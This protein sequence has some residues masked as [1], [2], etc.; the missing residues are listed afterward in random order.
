MRPSHRTSAITI[1]AALAATGLFVA[2][3]DARAQ[4]DTN[5][6]LP[7]VMLLVDT[8]GSMEYMMA[9][10]VDGKPVKPDCTKG[11]QNRWAALVSVL[12][13][14]VTGFSCSA[15]DRNSTAF[16]NEYS[17]GASAPYDKG[18]YLP[19]HRIS[20]N[21]CVKGPNTA[22]WPG[23]GSVYD[24]PSNSFV[25]HASSG[26][27]VTC[28]TP[29]A[30]ASDGLLDAFRSTARFGLMTFDTEPKSGTGVDS[31]G[32]IAT[33][34]FAGQWSYYP[35]WN[36]TGGGTPAKGAPAGCNELQG[37]EVGAR[38]AAAPPWEGRLIP[39]GDPYL[40]PSDVATRNDRLQEV[41]LAVRPYGATPIAAMMT[42][43]SYFL[44][45]DA[46]KDP[47]DATKSFGPKDDPYVLGGCRSDYIILLTDGAPN[48]DLRSDCE[49]TGGT[50]P[51]SKP[52][53]VARALAQP[54]NAAL[55]PVKT[56]VVGFALSKADG[57]TIDC[58]ALSTS[59]Q[60]DPNAV[61][62]TA[63]AQ[64]D[65]GLK[66]CCELGRIAWEGGTV[67]PRFADNKDQ[68]RKALNDI[69]SIVAAKS[70]TRTF[71]VFA[72]AP[73]VG[74]G[75]SGV[76][77]FNF[78]SAF[79]V[80]TGS[81]WEGVL[82]RQR[83]VCDA[84]HVP[85]PKPIA[86]QASDSFSENVN[87]Q[88]ASRPRYFMTVEPT[89]TDTG[90]YP[91][92]TIRKA[93]SGPYAQATWTTLGTDGLGAIDGTILDGGITDFYALP[94]I[95]ALG[96]DAVSPS[97]CASKD[98]PSI[99]TTQCRSRIMKWELGLDNGT[100][101]QRK[102][103]FGPILHSTPAVVPPP[104][105]FLRDESYLAFQGQQKNRPI[106][107]YTAT[108]DGQLHAFKVAA[109]STSDTFDVGTVNDGGSKQQ[110][111]LWS[112]FPPAVIPAIRS[113]YP[114]VQQTILDGAPVVRDVIL[115]RSRTQ[116]VNGTSL[117]TTALV[118]GLN[119]P[120]AGFYALDVTKPVHV[121]GDATT[122]PRFL[123]QI[124]TD[125]DGKSL[126]GGG[127][128]TPAITT[129]FIQAGSM[130]EPREVAVAILP[131][132][133]GSPIDTTTQCDRSETTSPHLDGATF[134]PRAKVPCYKDT[135][136]SRSLTIVRLD[137]GEVLARFQRKTNSLPVF[138]TSLEAR[139]HSAPFDSPLVG[140]PVVYP[141]GAGQ[142]SNRAFIGDR[143]GGLWRIDMSSTNPS[144]WSAHLFFDA[145]SV[146]TTLNGAFV[147]QPIS[148]PPAMSVDSVGNVVLLFSTGDQEQFNYA[149]GVNNVA[150]SLREKPD[151]VAGVVKTQE[152]WHL[153]F[154][155]TLENTPGVPSPL[156][157]PNGERVAGPISIFNGV[158]YFSSFKPQP[159][160]SGT[161]ICKAGSSTIWGV[162]YLQ[163]ID[164]TSDTAPK[165]RLVIHTGV[166]KPPLAEP[167]GDTLIFGV[168]ITRLPPCYAT[169]SFSDP[170][171][172]FQGSTTS[173]SSLN[174]GDYK[175]VVQTGKGGTNTAGGESQ[176]AVQQFNLAAP[177]TGVRM[178]SWAAV[179]E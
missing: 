85:Q 78:Y 154:G 63:K 17:I 42:D 151:L 166:T 153:G 37:I 165:G 136:V 144:N 122:G 134:G 14:E 150:W 33:D 43:A 125:E 117:W 124:T 148:T 126:F 159:P 137:N 96:V 66:A 138:S 119:G 48:M 89:P 69:L 162:D 36:A 51:F 172:G 129:L 56:F 114:G 146:K 128:L 167:Q 141:N 168:G 170:F 132:G 21:G 120:T 26:V 40:A 18:Y 64:T 152:N 121:A 90:V 25:E 161:D 131:G 158:A 123:W 83:I 10:G 2:P 41:L 71:P 156:T 77:G 12:T 65:E 38:N 24:F 108:T 104:S 97:T 145:F 67:N 29:F 53:D 140:I 13:G 116:A 133:S 62:G 57:G 177:P 87:V 163:S 103:V 101:Y 92:R 95:K 22:A 9:P 11:E 94:S 39:F 32:A 98:E 74:T 102:S 58:S 173:A 30:Q 174:P 4:A 112:F 27:G 16:V 178:T 84:S 176:T 155:E 105:E 47:L 70:T 111:E 110:N 139:T 7:N 6:P 81:L 142:I 179:V 79:K 28:T 86:T 135:D 45:S 8:S 88:D 68:L 91:T 76:A 115:E 99:S 1:S 5:P 175:L 55:S 106:V 100:A 160:G 169:E 3:R 20:S 93:G 73:S 35:N 130:T 113:L 61:C 54:S 15:L 49:A 72:P 60:F 143:D 34:P 107:L 52:S 171:L 157:W 149:S 147:G 75:G 46:S 44:T 59:A 109:T 19:H 31:N 118:S 23:T 82:E 164:A 50:C 127:A 80:S